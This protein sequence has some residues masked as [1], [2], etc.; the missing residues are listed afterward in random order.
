MINLKTLGHINIVV[1]EIN[2]AT[3]FYKQLFGAIPFQNFPHFKNE[4]FAKSAGF[5]DNPEEID[6]TIRFL[7]LPTQDNI[8]IELMEYHN[9]CGNSIKNIKK[10]NDRNLVGHIALKVDNI[11]E[12]FEHVK[13]VQGT[14]IINKSPN[15][16]PYKIDSID[17]SD[18]HFYDKNLEEDRDEKKKVCDIIENINF[19]YFI[20]KYGIQW[21]LEEG[22]SDIG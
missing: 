1:E 14:R 16:K 10:V 4:G 2:E 5:L 12:A 19:F 21:E 3:E 13:M 15:Y 7:K 6:V 22:H 8:V 18:F 9:P 17:V 20:D 11:E